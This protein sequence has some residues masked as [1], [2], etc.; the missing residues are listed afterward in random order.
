MRNKKAPGEYGITSEIFKGLVE[1]L[2]MYTTAIYNGCLRNISF[3]WRWKKATILPITKPGKESFEDVSKFRPISLL[4]IGGKVLEKVLINRINHHVF[5]QGFMNANQFG[6]IPLN[7][8]Q[9]RPWHLRLRFKKVWR[10][11]T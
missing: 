11:E 3:P 10:Q 6:F 1:I 2:P 7:V 4:N 9:K 8:P 5:S